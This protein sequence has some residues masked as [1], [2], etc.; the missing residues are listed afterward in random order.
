MTR[1]YTT[2]AL[3][4][5]KSPTNVGAVLRSAGCFNADEIL[6]SGNRFDLAKK[7]YTDTQDA[8]S[9]IPLI[10]VDDFIKEKPKGATIVCVDLIEGATPLAQFVHPEN[11]IYI[12]GPEDSSISQEVISQADVATYIPTVGCLNLAQTVNVVLYDRASK[13]ELVDSSDELIRK[14]RDRNNATTVKV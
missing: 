5:P 3:T 10:H 7:F 4:N 13:L 12:F 2:I 11:A 9:N 8:N 6:Y 1:R 14:S